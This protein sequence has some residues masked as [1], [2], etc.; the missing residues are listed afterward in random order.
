MLRINNLEI[1]NEFM[2]L[3]NEEKEDNIYEPRILSDR[4]GKRYQKFDNVIDRKA[5][6]REK[7]IKMK[8][9]T[10]YYNDN[11]KKMTC[12]FCERKVI[13][14]TISKHNASKKCLLFQD[15]IKVLQNI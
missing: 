15:Y 6:Y 3:Y 13:G 11:K 12:P 10:K 4:I 7:N 2:D 9:S 8:Y 5:F 1:V 14:L